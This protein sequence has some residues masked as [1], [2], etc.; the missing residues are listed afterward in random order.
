MVRERKDPTD[1]SDQGFDANKS[2]NL[3][4]ELRKADK[5]QGET[6]DPEFTM[7]RQ[8]VDI[9]GDATAEKKG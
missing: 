4:E 7:N 6:V 1:P 5:W 8:P 3:E 9:R 2:V